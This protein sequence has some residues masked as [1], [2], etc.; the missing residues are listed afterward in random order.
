MKRRWVLESVG[1]SLLLMFPYFSALEDPR[2][3]IVYHHRLPMTHLVGGILLDMAG[4]TILGVLAMRFFHASGPRWKRIAEILFLTLLA[5]RLIGVFV[6]FLGTI[7]NGGRTDY[8]VLTRHADLNALLLFWDQA[9]HP[10]LLILILGFAFCGW[11][12]PE[13]WRR[14]LAGMRVTLASIAF[15][16][17]WVIPQMLYIAFRA[18]SYPAFD[19]SHTVAASSQPR[20]IVW[21]LFDELS[22]K[23]TFESSA[24]QDMPY[25]HALAADSTLFANMHPIGFRT[26][27]IG[28][29]ILTDQVIDQIKATRQG[30]LLVKEDGKPAWE[31]FD[32]GKSIFSLAYSAG[33]NPAVD[34][35]YN[36]YC[37]LFRDELTACSWQPAIHSYI[38]AEAIGASKDHSAFAN[39]LI[40]P[41]SFVSRLFLRQSPDKLVRLQNIDDYRA[42]MS[43]ASA[44]IQNPKLH[45]IFVHL[46]VPHP[47]GIYDRKTHHLR[48][49]GNYLD[50]LVLADD[51][52]GELMREIA[53]TPWA[54][55]T[56]LIVSSDHSWRLPLWENG[57]DWTPEEESVSQGRF[58]QR[59]VFLVHFPGQTAPVKI[60]APVSELLEHDLIAKMLEGQIKSAEDMNESV[61][62]TTAASMAS[63]DGSAR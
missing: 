41:A 35:W 50:N 37:R 40:I 34:G 14:L 22:Y 63:K 3:L 23:L 27:K 7:L 32:P 15:C 29:S 21:L 19:H 60:T 46:P 24:V 36:P 38:E 47:P 57:P 54:N 51:T 25:L 11:K 39:A 20:R 49:G 6:F 58:D 42:V 10:I 28:P 52:L 2:A 62:R 8:E 30:E 61:E 5:W 59:P 53:A 26:D 13:I 44:F 9:A 4:I 12:F 1:A 43:N 33:W 31:R 16:T 56:T 18:P 17:L 45:F 48:P 55:E